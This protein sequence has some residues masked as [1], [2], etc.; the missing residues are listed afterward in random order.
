[1]RTMKKINNKILVIGLA[2]LV[3]IFVISKI[4]RSPRLEGNLRKE[5]VKLDTAEISEIRMTSSGDQPK[6]VKLIRA[7]NKWTVVQDDKTY[8]A[9]K[10]S[11]NN[12]LSTVADLNAVRMVSR[13]KEKWDSYNVGEK[14]TNVSVYVDGSPKAEFRVG[15]TGFNQNPTQQ[16]FGRQG[17]EAFTYVRM[18][19]EDE[20]Y[21]V[22]GF[23]EASFNKSVND[24][25]DRSFLRFAPAEVSKV[26]FQYP[27]DSSFVLEKRDSVWVNGNENADKAKVDAY[28][29]EFSYRSETSFADTFSATSAPTYSIRFDGVSGTLATVEAWRQDTNWYLRSSRQPDVVFLNNDQSTMSRLFPGPSKF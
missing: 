21:M 23:L 9:D 22:N 1:V 2:G 4:F 7:E 29:R 11:V 5:L 15:K 16:Q 20:V 13:K 12:I 27:A 19:D 8:P 17:I 24:W 28:V 10:S 26:S 25:R 14:G 6:L 3:A 18:T